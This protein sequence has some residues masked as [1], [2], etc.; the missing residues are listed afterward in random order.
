MNGPIPSSLRASAGCAAAAGDFTLLFHDTH[1]RAV[2][3]AADISRL[4]LGDYDGV[5][6]FGEAVRQRYLDAGWAGQVFTW[7]EAADTELFRPQPQVKRESDIV[8]IGNW[9]DDERSARTARVS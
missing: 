1:H 7:H 8:W 9:G 3:T 5:L 2:T 6:A 4:P